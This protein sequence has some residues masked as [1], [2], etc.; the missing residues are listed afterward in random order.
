MTRAEVVSFLTQIEESYSV[1]DWQVVG[2]D[3]W[4]V[5]KRTVFFMWHHAKHQEPSVEVPQKEH[6]LASFVLKVKNFLVYKRHIYRGKRAWKKI[7][8]M[9][10]IDTL[11]IGNHAHR[12]SY[13]GAFVNRYYEPMILNGEVSSYLEIEYGENRTHTERYKRENELFF[14]EDLVLAC[15]ARNRA[16]VG[17]QE[18][19][20]LEN[21]S[22]INSHVCS[23]LGI[24]ILAVQAALTAATIRIYLAHT[25]FVRLLEALKV[26]RVYTLCYYTTD[27]FGLY[28][29]CHERTIPAW[30]VQ[31]GGQGPLHVMYT[32]HPL[33][34]TRLLN[35]VPSHFWCW[36]EY[37]A[38]HINKGL[39]QSSYYTTCVQGNPWID[40]L[41]ENFSN[42]SISLEQDKQIILY[43]LQEDRLDAWLV[44]A[45]KASKNNWI[46]YLRLHPRM[47]EAKQNIIEQL[48]SANVSSTQYEIDRATSEPL[49]RCLYYAAVHIS[50][51]S[52]SIIEA[53]LMGTPTIIIDTI[54]ANT[55]ANLVESGEAVVYLGNNA[56][57]LWYCI[58]NAVKATYH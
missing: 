58:E 13:D 12:V 11:F 27:L 49:P 16:V 1:Y 56:S 20:R 57:D 32:F 40:F 21:W 43:T 14:L 30:D 5:Y 52:G 36:D 39:G 45:I 47:T 54:G 33:S 38:V 50:K 26:K 25:V 9:E 24:D 7:L 3:V 29:A 34:K 48:H 44:D 35:T 55:Y 15:Q 17:A 2:V 41:K 10:T 42:E 31:H 8:N 19:E 28:K 6:A 22:E 4:P 46:W 37:S 53:A 23:K 18:I 51:F